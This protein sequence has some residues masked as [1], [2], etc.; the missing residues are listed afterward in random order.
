M[1]ELNTLARGDAMALLLEFGDT[2]L[3]NLKLALEAQI[4]EFVQGF[5]HFCPTDLFTPDN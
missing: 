2:Q 3:P 1:A 4:C 5:A